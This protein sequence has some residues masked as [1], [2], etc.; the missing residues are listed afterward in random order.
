M[1]D[2]RISAFTTFVALPRKNGDLAVASFSCVARGV[3]LRHCTL[4][5]RASGGFGL[6]WPRAGRPEPVYVIDDPELRDAVIERAAVAY[7][8]LGRAEPEDA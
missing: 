5:R 3:S 6:S 7:E 1:A 4:V 2:V 8:A